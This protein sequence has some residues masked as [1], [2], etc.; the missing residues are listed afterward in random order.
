MEKIVTTRG[1]LDALKGYAGVIYLDLVEEITIEDVFKGDLILR[2]GTIQYVGGSATIQDVGGSATIQYVRG[3]ATVK[4]VRDSATITNLLNGTIVR[5]SGNSIVIV[6]K[7]PT[8]APESING[9]AQVIHT[10]DLPLITTQSWLDQ[11][12]IKA[13]R[14]KAVLYKRVSGDWQTQENT[15]NATVWAPG[16]TL[17]HT[18][19][20]PTSGECGAGRYHGVFSPRQADKFRSLPGD[21][22]V[23]IQIAVKDLYAWPT[24]PEYPEKIAFRAGKVLHECDSDGNKI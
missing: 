15:A 24:D 20:D 10:G 2:S 16:T 19:W 12:G 4:D 18:S 8:F 11:W 22:Y 7:N 9:N 3:S 23:A 6:R 14:G 17:V 5:I 21:R 1:E 13:T